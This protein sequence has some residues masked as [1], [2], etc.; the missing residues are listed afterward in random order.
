MV[1]DVVS[2]VIYEGVC[3]SYDHNTTSDKGDVVVS[4]R[5]L[6]LPLKKDCWMVRGVIPQEGDVVVVD[7]GVYEEY[8]VVTDKMPGNL[9]T[10]ILWKYVRN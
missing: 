7:K 6:A 8:G 9:G 4:N 1:D 3:R 5:K 10:T 2:T